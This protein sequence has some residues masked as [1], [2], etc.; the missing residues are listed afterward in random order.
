MVGL[1]GIGKTTLIEKHQQAITQKYGVEISISSDSVIS[2]IAQMLGKTYADV[3]LEA[4]DLATKYVENTIGIFSIS[5]RSFIVDQT[6]M[7]EHG[8]KAKLGKL[9]NSKDYKKIVVVFPNDSVS[10]EDLRIRL[11][12]RAKEEGKIITEKLIND[13]TSR[14]EYPSLGEGWDQVLTVDQFLATLPHSTYGGGLAF[15]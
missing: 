5:K 7:T 6:N 3:F 13:M 2:D 8:R 9:K 14:F 4:I 11:D 10:P 12:E 1:P 15:A